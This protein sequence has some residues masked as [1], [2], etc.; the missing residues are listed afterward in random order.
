MSSLIFNFGV[1]T[2]NFATAVANLEQAKAAILPSAQAVQSAATA[3]LA[4]T[5][6]SISP[7]SGPVAGG[8]VVTITGTQLLGSTAVL[9]QDL[10]GGT[11]VP[12]AS[13]IVIDDSTITAI[14]PG[15]TGDFGVIVDTSWG[16]A[17]N[18]P[19]FTYI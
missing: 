7:D 4:P 19:T 2:Y 3:M 17:D 1:A 10:T 11:Y 13:F 9:L 6:T 5:V 18:H 15:G 12:A 14:T 16:S 8:T